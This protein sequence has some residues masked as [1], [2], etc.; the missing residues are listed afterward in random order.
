MTYTVVGFHVATTVYLLLRNSVYLTA[1]SVIV[2]QWRLVTNCKLLICWP[3]PPTEN[4]IVLF[5]LKM[6]MS[7]FLPILLKTLKKSMNRILV[8][9]PPNFVSWHISIS[10]THDQAVI[11][12]GLRY[13]MQYMSLYK[14][15]LNFYNYYLIHV[16]LSIFYLFSYFF[17]YRKMSEW[18]NW[19]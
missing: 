11:Y 16:S 8:C 3:S 15:Q 14:Y 7:D 19:K 6:P 5:S 10:N 17:F 2:V 9:L 4:I 13:Y 12:F 1:V 18:I